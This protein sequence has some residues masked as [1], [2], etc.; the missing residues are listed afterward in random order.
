MAKKEG[1]VTKYDAVERFRFLKSAYSKLN[2]DRFK[3]LQG[4]EVNMCGAIA[5]GNY[6][7]ATNN[8]FVGKILIPDNKPAHTAYYYDYTEP[9]QQVFAA[10]GQDVPIKDVVP[11][12]NKN[13]QQQPIFYN[14]NTEKW[15]ENIPLETI[16][17]E[18]MKEIKKVFF[19]WRDNLIKIE[20]NIF[21][22]EIDNIFG[23]KDIEKTKYSVLISQNIER[24]VVI[25]KLM[26]RTQKKKDSIIFEI[27]L[28]INPSRDI[29]DFYTPPAI[30]SVN[31]YYLY[32]LI[33]TFKEYDIVDFA[34][35]NKFE[36]PVIL[37]GV[38]P[39]VDWKPDIRFALGQD[40]PKYS[41][42]EKS[43]Y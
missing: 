33:S 10:K 43:M 22:Q 18:N 12:D 32:H 13:R 3:D 8:H 29:S 35:D 4:N 36:T 6:V 30:C 34:Y 31:C 15:E 5:F 21:L 1:V 2:D 20:K 14:F 9:D 27:P 40:R 26:H 7:Y 25:F 28:H 41:Y 17:K 23:R 24:G 38:N 11:H 16:I 37:K 19:N 42:P 39:R